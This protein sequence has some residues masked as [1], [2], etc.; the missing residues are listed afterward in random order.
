L[1]DWN[2]AFE[3]R[4]DVV[5]EEEEEGGVGEGKGEE[6]S[7]SLEKLMLEKKNENWEMLKNGRVNGKIGRVDVD[8]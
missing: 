4:R 5:R 7:R 2:V 8:N 3:V 6:W 1:N